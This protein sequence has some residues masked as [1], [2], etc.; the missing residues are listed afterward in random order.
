MPKVSFLGFIIAQGQLQPDPAKIQAVEEL[1]TPMTC[2]QLQ[3]LHGFAN[4]YRRFIKDFSQVA[5]PVHQL[6]SA[7]ASFTWTPSSGAAFLRLK[8]LFMQAPILLHP[9]SARQ[10]V[11][12][13]DASDSSVWRHPVPA[14]RNK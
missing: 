9:D 5:A 1:P 2:K 6:T 13:V 4:F 8:R 12:E 7:S 10:F 14:Q 11:V 3:R